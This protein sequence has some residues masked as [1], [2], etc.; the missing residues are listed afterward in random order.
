MPPI[1]VSSGVSVSAVPPGTAMVLSFP[2]ATNAIDRLSG[3]QAGSMMVRAV[4]VPSIIRASSPSS[5]RSQ[6]AK[7]DP[8]PL[9]TNAKR[10]PSGEIAI[11]WLIGAPVTG[12]SNRV[13]GRDSGR[14]RPYDIAMRLAATMPTVATAAAT[15]R[16]LP[17]VL[18]A[19][20]AVLTLRSDAPRSVAPRIAAASAASLN[21]AAGSLSRHRPISHRRCDGVL[22]GS[23]SSFG[24]CVTTAA[25]MS[26]TVSPANIARPVSIS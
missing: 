20:D 26:V 8:P 10:R 16:L 24:S 15:H 14:D 22:A 7:R 2:S 9:A 23:A 12:I 21:R 4:S 19:G 3:D 5:E 18:T 11:A 25:R 17:E 13:T 1:C 6:S